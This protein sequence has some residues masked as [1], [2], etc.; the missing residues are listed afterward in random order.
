MISL[1]L[2]ILAGVFNAIM[3]VLK[4]RFGTSI[5]AGLKHQNWINPSISWKNKW[6]NGDINQG[7]RFFGSST[8]LVWLTDL[9]HFAK[10][11]MLCC[12]CL[13]IILYTPLVTKSLDFLILLCGFTCTFQILFGYVLIKK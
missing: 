2:I 5:F 7:E 3:D 8:F 10:M 13:S 6:K 9:W 11:C 4:V 12:V 1:V